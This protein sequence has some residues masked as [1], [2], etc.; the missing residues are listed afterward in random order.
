MK[1]T[2]KKMISF[3][4]GTMIL[5][6]ISTTS[7]AASDD[8]WTEAIQTEAAKNGAWEKWCE[9]WKIIKDDWTQMS[10][11]PGRTESELNFGW[12]SKKGE[13]PAQIKIGQ[14]ADLSDAKLLTVTTEE[15]VPGYESNKAVAKGLKANTTY[16]YSYTKDGKWQ[17]ANKYQTRNPYSYSFCFVGDPQIGSSSDNIA[18]DATKKQGQDVAARNDSFNWANTINTA[19]SLR[20]NAS[21]IVSAGDQI[22]TIDKTNK[23]PMFTGNEIEYAGYLSPEALKG[24]PVATTIGNHDALSKNYTFH[25]NNPNITELGTTNAGG[26]Y[27][28]SYGDALFIVLNTNSDNIKE[29]EQLMKKAIASDSD[30]KWRIVTLHQ[31]IYGSGEHSNE[32]EIANLRY[33]LVPIFEENDVD[34]VLSG[35]DHTYSRSFFLEGA[36]LYEDTMIT[37]DEFEAYFEGEKLVD[38]TYTKYLD[39]IEDKAAIKT[40]AVSGTVTNPKG[41]LYL[42]ANSASGSKYYK[43]VEKQQAYINIRWQEE[44]PTFSI[45]DITSDSMTINTYRTDTL[46]QIEEPLTIVKR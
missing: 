37:D 13:V 4:I 28:Y 38:D 14:K 27:Y 44:V 29:H 42:T 22:Q 34:I 43:L 11:T 8:G 36:K 3:L 46:E 19:L 32:P 16:Y 30:A 2:R 21:F 10:L 18:I 39:G 25:F 17:E 45:I 6:S 35:H 9:K 41:I 23:D 1:N 5:A 31:D 12:Y 24:L 20:P 33:N 7:F 40:K 15:A 26:D